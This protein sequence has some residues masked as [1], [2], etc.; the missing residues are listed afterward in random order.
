MFGPS[1]TLVPVVVSPHT[2]L[3]MEQEN[4]LDAADFHDIQALS[5]EA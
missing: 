1:G 4:W 5:V 2:R 3:S